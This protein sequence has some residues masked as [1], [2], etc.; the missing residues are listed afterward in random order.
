MNLRNRWAGYWFLAPYLL[1]FTV[2]TLGPLLFGLGLS[3]TEY[4][5]AHNE[6]ARF[7]GVA[8][9]NEAINSDFFWRSLWATVKF[10]LL[11]VPITIPLALLLAVAIDSARGGRQAIYR[12]GVFA[13]TVVTISVVGLMWRWFYDREFGLFNALLGPVLRRSTDVGVWLHSLQFADASPNKFQSVCNFVVRHIGDAFI[14]NTPVGFLDTPNS[15]M[16]SIVVMTIWWTIG[17]PVLVLLAGLKQIPSHYYEA[18]AIDGA[19]GWRAFWSIT[20]P[21]MRPALLFTLVINIIGA[22]QVFG[23]P[24]MVTNGGPVLSTRVA[25]MYIYETAF[26]NYRLGYGAA[27]SWLLFLVIAVF[28]ILQFRLMRDDGGDQTVKVAGAQKRPTR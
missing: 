23:Q 27:M 8:N 20:L 2:F 12:I 13:P 17:G 25:M 10:V 26:A 5:L 24:Y 1:L 7:A 18:A 3:F 19:T 6:P 11:S 14:I 15:A 28:A 16:T 9:Y 21:A 4:D 22:F